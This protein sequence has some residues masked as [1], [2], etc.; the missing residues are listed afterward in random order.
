V[1]AVGGTELNLNASGGHASPDTVWND[2]YDTAVTKVWFHSSKPV[3]SA[4]GGGRSV[5]FSRPSYQASVWR[6]VG[7]SRG[8]PDI[9][10]DAACSSSVEVYAAFPGVT[11]GWST[12]CGTSVA[13]PLFAGIVALA[14][15]VARHP[16]GLI[17]PAIYKLAAEHAPGIVEV[18]SGNNTVSFTHGGSKHTVHG[19]T[20]RDGY[21]RVAGVGTIDGQYFVPEL[22]RLG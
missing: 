11:P 2:T 10:M 4:G 6:T 1:T 20:A 3:P 21:S 15:Q 16:L 7:D 19:Y 8:I 14:D 13:T 17:N 18:T 22:A 12:F 5:I 9:S